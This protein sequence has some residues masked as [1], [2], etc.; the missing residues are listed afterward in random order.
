[1]ETKMLPVPGFPDYRVDV[2][3]NVYRARVRQD[4]RL[5]LRRV[6]PYVRKG[7]GRAFVDLRNHKAGKRSNARVHRVVL[8]TFVGPCPAGMECDHKDGNCLNN[9]LDNLQWVT[10]KE[11]KANP[12]SPCPCGEDRHN[13]KLTWPKVRAIRASGA[14]CMAE[15]RALAEAF[16]VAL[17][18]LY[19]VVMG[20]TWKH[21]PESIR[22]SNSV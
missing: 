9:R 4:G 16:G 1:M 22:D 7:D 19:S 5:T 13:A 8:E 10:S 6:R 18:T 11:N 12:N 2:E 17:M 15:Y 20:K 21:D 3:G 14:C